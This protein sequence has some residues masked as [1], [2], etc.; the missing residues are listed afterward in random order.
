[1]GI[2]YFLTYGQ[3]EMLTLL[4]KALGPAEVVTWAILGYVWSILKYIS[5][6]FADAAES[7]CFL[8][9]ASNEPDL[10]RSSAAKSQL[11]GFF[12]S[13]LVTSLLFIIGMELTKAITPDRTLQRLMV[14]TFPLIGMGNVVQATSTISSSL[15]GVQGRGGLAILVQFLGNWCIGIILGSIFTYG[16]QI[17]LQGLTSAVVLGLALSGAGN[18]YL[19]LRSEWDALASILSEEL[20]APINQKP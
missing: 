6:G 3:W 19:L 12:S 8:H 17:D 1:M 20:D 18:G 5:D 2:A 15:L 7:R 14:E 16:L 10:A 11:L 4:A 9:L 13:L